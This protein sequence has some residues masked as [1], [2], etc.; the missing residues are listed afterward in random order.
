MSTKKKILV[1][2]SAVVSVVAIVAASVFGTVAYLT[3]SRYDA[4]LP[5]KSE[6]KSTYENITVIVA[7]MDEIPQFAF[8]Q[9]NGGEE[10]VVLCPPEI[11]FQV[12]IA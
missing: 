5:Y 6:K 7:N 1:A 11:A 10:D 2:L 4:D 9:A 8:K 3:E 12:A